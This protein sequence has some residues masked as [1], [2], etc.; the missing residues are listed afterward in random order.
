MIRKYLIKF[1]NNIKL[2]N[3]FLIM[4]LFC[5]IIPL[6]ITNALVFNSIYIKEYNNRVHELDD[7]ASSY[8]STIDSAL[9]YN[10]RI[11]RA[12]SGNQQLN[13]FLN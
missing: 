2:H 9:D 11:A 3:K 13:A 8:I 4:Y 6:V 10:V 7:V 12:I 5:V 1:L